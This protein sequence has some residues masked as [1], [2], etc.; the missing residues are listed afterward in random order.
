MSGVG[1][2]CAIAHY[3]AVLFEFKINVFYKGQIQ[4]LSA[5]L[6]FIFATNSDKRYDQ[7]RRGLEITKTFIWF[8][9]KKFSTYQSESFEWVVNSWNGD[10][11]F[12]FSACKST[13][14]LE[15]FLYQKADNNFFFLK[16][17]LKF[18]QNIDIGEFMDIDIDIDFTNS[19]ISTESIT[20]TTMWENYYERKNSF[21][22]G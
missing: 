22:Q 4:H 20:G 9:V 14:D 15:K 2:L 21:V 12:G 17:L 6:S 16:K 19:I 13:A 8:V 7:V 10:M 11:N 18:H 1:T 5:K 3:R